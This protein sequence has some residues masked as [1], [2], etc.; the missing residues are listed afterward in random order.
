[1]LGAEDRQKKIMTNL[2]GSE[3][4]LMKR[5]EKNKT[6]TARIR[7][8]EL[9]KKQSR[10]HLRKKP[11]TYRNKPEKKTKKTKCAVYASTNQL[12]KRQ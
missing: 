7:T 11:T 6:I 1:V 9:I 12:G 4:I 10:N 8:E 3:K 2:I 5:G